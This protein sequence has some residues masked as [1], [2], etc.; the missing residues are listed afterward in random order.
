MTE[1]LYHLWFSGQQADMT[2]M[3]RAAGHCWY[4]LVEASAATAMRRGCEALIQGEMPLVD[5][6]EASLDTT[7]SGLWTDYVYLG[8]GYWSGR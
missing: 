8:R 1:K 7:P 2:R 5:V 6:T 3:V 4:R